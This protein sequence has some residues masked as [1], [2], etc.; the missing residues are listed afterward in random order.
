MLTTI[1][2]QKNLDFQKCLQEVRI[3]KC[4]EKTLE[5]LNSRVGLEYN[6]K[7]DIIPTTLFTTRENVSNMNNKKF[8][9]I[10]TRNS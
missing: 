3:N 8:T 6:E 1:I 10:K 2:R 5:L 4:S 9:K 7:S